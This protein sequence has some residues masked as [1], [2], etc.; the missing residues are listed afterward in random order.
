MLVTQLAANRE[1]LLVVACRGLEVTGLLRIEEEVEEGYV[2][3]LVSLDDI[4]SVRAT[5]KVGRD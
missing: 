1:A 4:T 3:N 2:V 5:E